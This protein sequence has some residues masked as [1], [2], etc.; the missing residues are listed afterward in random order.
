MSQYVQSNQI[1]V[2]STH[3]RIR[4]APSTTRMITFRWL[5]EEFKYQED[6]DND[7]GDDDDD[8]DDGDA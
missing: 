2:F 8:D 6:D 7:D 1:I 5:K 3:S 4:L